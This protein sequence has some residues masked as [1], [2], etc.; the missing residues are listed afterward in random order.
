M[1]LA[2]IDVVRGRSPEELR[3]LADAVQEVLVD[4]FAA[5]ERDRY[6]VIAQHEEDELVLWDTGLGFERSA[7]RVLV[8]ITQQ[9]RDRGQKEALY[10]ALAQRLEERGV[11]PPEDLVVSVVANEPEDWSFGHG[12]AQF[13]TGEL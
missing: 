5:P 13:L 1:P 4:V 2:R 10:A 7:R 3:T 11:C 9:G 8:Q 12:R 6:Q